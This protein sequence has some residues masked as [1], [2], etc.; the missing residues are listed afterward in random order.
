MTLF[1]VCAL[2]GAHIR[3]RVLESAIPSHISS[4]FLSTQIN[5][6]HVECIVFVDKN[7]NP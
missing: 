6:R 2:C 3:G 1:N 5:K 4:Y 7:E